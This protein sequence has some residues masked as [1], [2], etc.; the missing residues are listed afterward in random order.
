[1]ILMIPLETVL[2]R[3]GEGIEEII[4]KDH[5][6]LL[7]TIDGNHLNDQN[8]L[9]EIALNLHPKWDLLRQKETRDIIIKSL[10]RD[11]AEELAFIL[12]IGYEG[13]PYKAIIQEK[14]RK[15][16]RSEIN[17]FG[18][19]M[20]SLP[21]KEEKQIMDTVETIRTKYGLYEHQRNALYKVENI[22]SK[23]GEGRVM[24]HMPTGS[25]K[26]RTAMN[27][28]ARH[29]N[30]NPGSLVL[31]L[32]HSE[33]L[34][35]QAVEEFTDTWS[36]LGDREVSVRRFFGN[37]KWEEIEEG[38]IVAGL[39]KMWSYVKSTTNKLFFDAKNI[40]LIIFDE[41]HQSTAETFQL[42]VKMILMKNQNCKLLGLTA[43]PG[44]TWQD[45]TEDKKLSEFY[46]RQKVP[47]EVSGYES[48][49][50]YLIE[51]GYLSK[52]IFT[53]IKYPGNLE[54]TK[55]ERE[56]IIQ[57][58]DIPKK[59]LD[60]LS[61]NGIRNRVIIDQIQ[62]LV[63][64]GNHKRILVFAINVKHAKT[65]NSF[66]NYMG[67]S[68]SVIT[69]E[70]DKQTRKEEISKFKQHGDGVRILCNYGV[71]TTGFDAPKTSAAVITRPTKSLVLYSQM[72]GRAIRGKKVG[73][74]SEAEICTVID[75]HLPGFG[76]LNEAFTN[77]DDVWN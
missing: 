13:S 41:A 24:L 49:M 34:C 44:R 55:S 43:T 40:S 45:I 47:L 16:S 2:N 29:L 67:F 75:S 25:G 23:E 3:M 33:E 18:F 48:P 11:E 21:E 8:K 32:A 62:R 22:L 72:V 14:I 52:P 39:S 36:H 37:H 20:F 54:L 31:W 50:D 38:V 5:Y 69:G 10:N 51:E 57:S 59:I 28:I 53:P 17:L 27:L 71:L 46:N 73:G 68:S 6:R 9:I 63:I 64:S 7:K 74:T 12:G 4:G 60:R 56:N 30:R 26:T 66:L 42:P 65:I 15:N 19:F 76:N 35:E 58:L 61:E 70:T 1:M 77:W